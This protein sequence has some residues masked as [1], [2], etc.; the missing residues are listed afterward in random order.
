[1]PCRL[2][3]KNS[4]EV[5]YLLIDEN[6]ILRKSLSSL[7]SIFSDSASDVANFNARCSEYDSLTVMVLRLASPR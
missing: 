2:E 3:E 1:M 4:L 7:S 6:F 5:L